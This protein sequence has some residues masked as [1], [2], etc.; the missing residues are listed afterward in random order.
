MASISIILMVWS[1]RRA[2]I[3]FRFPVAVASS[4]VAAFEVDRGP[5]SCCIGQQTRAGMAVAASSSAGLSLSYIGCPS[6]AGQVVVRLRVVCGQAV[7]TVVDWHKCLST[8]ALTGVHRPAATV[9]M[10]TSAYSCRHICTAA[11]EP[12]VEKHLSTSVSQVY[13]RLSRIQLCTA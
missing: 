5:G 13:T 9:C 6:A 11:I 1:I 8:F 7:W 4:S 3:A 12:D 2:Y 10:H